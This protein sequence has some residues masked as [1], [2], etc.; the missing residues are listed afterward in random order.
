MPD[1]IFDDAAVHDVFDKLQSHAMTLGLFET[2]NTHEAKGAPGNGLWCA[3]W[4]Q[5]IGPVRSS[6]MAATSGRL[7]LMARVGSNFIAKPEDGID[8]NILSA[9]TTLIG[10]YSSNFTLGGTVR[11]IDLLG[12][13]GVPLSAQAG[14]LDISGKFFRIMDITVP[15][16]INDLWSQNA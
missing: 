3:I 4:V 5:R 12:A 6:G 16:V 7:E 2:V 11:E 10:K 1:M 14:Y 9:V 15:I 13:E 8:P